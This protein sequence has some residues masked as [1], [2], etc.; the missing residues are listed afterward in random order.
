MFLVFVCGGR[1]LGFESRS[2]H[3]DLSFLQVVIWLKYYIYYWNE[4]KSH[5]KTNLWA[6]SRLGLTHLKGHGHDWWS[7]FTI[8][9]YTKLL[10]ISSMKQSLKRMT[11][12][13]L[14]LHWVELHAAFEER[15][16]KQ[17]N[18]KFFFTNLELS[19]FSNKFAFVM[20][21]CGKRKI[22]L[23]YAM[24]ININ[25]SWQCLQ[26]KTSMSDF[27]SVYCSILSKIVCTFLDDFQ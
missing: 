10:Y 5:Q 11:I 8:S 9:F 13:K 3:C 27:S 4:R 24:C 18:A 21:F 7:L 16:N 14:I 17:K 19:F 26:T 25:G 1:S 23:N 20:Q 22:T 15:E 2:C 12:F 6:S